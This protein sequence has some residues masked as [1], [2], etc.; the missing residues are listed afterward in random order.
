M[1][2]EREAVLKIIQAVGRPVTPKEI[3]DRLG[4][5]P[6]TIRV[7]FFALKQAGL[8]KPAG[9][10]GK[11]ELANASLML[12][13]AL[14]TLA[15]VAGRQKTNA[16]PNASLM[17]S[18][19]ALKP[20]KKASQGELSDIEKARIA[21][22]IEQNKRNAKNRERRRELNRKWREANP[23]KAKACSKQWREA[24][25]DRVKE[26]RIKRYAKKYDQGAGA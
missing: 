13:N 17:V 7:M 9:K 19:N 25:Q 16:L 12:P 3:A 8:I 18:G 5:K 4:K 20:E 6:N 11:W 14:K 10:Y 24:N 1:T 15:S 21:Y 22:N 26:S 23:E 2:P